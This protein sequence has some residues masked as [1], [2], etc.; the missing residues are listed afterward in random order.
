MTATEGGLRRRLTA[1]AAVIGSSALLVGSLAAT[2][3]VASATGKAPTE[4]QIAAMRARA[5]K[6]GAE[7]SH[8]QQAVDLAA[9]RYDESVLALGKARARLAATEQALGVLQGRLK[10]ETSDLRKAAI[11]AYVTDDGATD[12]VTALLYS[13]VND[14]GSIAAYASSVTDRLDSTVQALLRTRAS[15]VREKA[16]QAREEHQAAA[17]VKQATAARTAAEQETAQIKSILHEV[18]GQLARM[19]VQHERWLAAV[20]AARARRIREAKIAAEKAAQ[21]AAAAAAAAAVAQADP[22]SGSAGSQGAGGGVGGPPVGPVGSTTEGIAAVH[23]AE[24]Y[25]GVPYV[26]GGASRAGVDC[27]GLTMLAWAAAGVQLEHG[28]TAQWQA[29][30]RVSTSQ[31]QPGDLL[32]YHFAN[33]GPWP[34]THVAMY[35]GSG[36][37]GKNTIIQAEE[38]GTNVGFFPIYW[39][40]FVSAGRP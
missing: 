1:A 5:A 27:S 15:V 23:A 6:L 28:A 20:A 26:W 12:Q 3:G 22:G 31:L 7:L 9:E 25:I 30:Q 13:N 32:F 33:D 39:S 10:S 17:A 38:T 21:A 36:P 18:R 35:V 19:I 24:S 16:V 37:F 4:S 2:G 34:I 11:E 29:S 40:G 14:L 8:D